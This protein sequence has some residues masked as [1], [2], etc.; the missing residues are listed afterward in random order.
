MTT[1]E[2]IERLDVMQRQILHGSRMFADIA[3]VIRNSE[4]VRVAARR[5]VKI[6][7][8]QCT[9][10]RIPEQALQLAHRILANNRPDGEFA[11]MVENHR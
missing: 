9:R 10:E 7:I 1:E 5:Q 11:G 6:A 2:A 8:E 3:D 4:K